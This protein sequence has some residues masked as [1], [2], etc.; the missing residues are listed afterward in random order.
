[1]KHERDNRKVYE[2]AGLAGTIHVRVVNE[3]LEHIVCV[4][5]SDGETKEHR[6]FWDSL[7]DDEPHLKREREER[8]I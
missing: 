4:Y 8:E 5:T 1:M 6:R 3:G 2:P 7:G